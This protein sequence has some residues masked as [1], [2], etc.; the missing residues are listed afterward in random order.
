MVQSF[1]E[2]P[3][4]NHLQQDTSSILKKKKSI[5]DSLFFILTQDPSRPVLNNSNTHIKPHTLITH[6][7]M[8][9][10]SHPLH[11]SSTSV[12]EGSL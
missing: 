6:Y 2:G 11:R 5:S 9:T 12:T 7:N 10:C 1:V 3:L 4:G 8:Y